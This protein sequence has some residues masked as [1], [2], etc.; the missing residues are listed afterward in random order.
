[1][2]LDESQETD[3]IFTDRGIK[4]SIDKD[5][6]DDVKPIKVD[7]IKS[8]RGSGFKLTSNLDAGARLGSSC[9]G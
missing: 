4:Y 6:F 5:L 3:L 2:A 9:C 1:M 7:F 8:F